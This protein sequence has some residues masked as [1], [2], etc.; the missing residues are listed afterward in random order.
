METVDLKYVVTMYTLKKMDIDKVIKFRTYIPV[1]EKLN[2]IDEYIKSLEC[3][4][5]G[6][7]YLDSFEQYFKFT[8]LAVKL[9]TNIKIDMTYE[10]YDLLVKNGLLNEI[11]TYVQEDYADLKGFMQMKLND[12]LRKLA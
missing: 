8:M 11:F 12:C 4:T 5:K 2:A 10:E 3:Y 9:Y 7:E 1:S 6:K